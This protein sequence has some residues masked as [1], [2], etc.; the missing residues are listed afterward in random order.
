MPSRLVRELICR[1]CPFIAKAVVEALK[2]N[3]RFNANIDTEAGTITYGASE[4]IG[5]AVDTPRG[6]LVPVIRG[7]R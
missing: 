1:I 4:N 6:L 2:Q 7:R 3:P 5:I